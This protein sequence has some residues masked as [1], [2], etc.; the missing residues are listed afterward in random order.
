MKKYIMSMKLSIK[1]NSMFKMDYFLSF[2]SMPIEILII[3]LFWRNSLPKSNSIGYTLNTLVIYFVFFQTLQIAYVSAMFVAYEL[4]TKINDGTI[5]VWLIRP[6]SYPLYVFANKMAIFLPKFI[7]S[8]SVI[9]SVLFFLGYRIKT[10][11]LLLGILSAILGYIIL[12][13]IQYVI[14]SLTYYMKKVISFRDAV[15]SSLFLIGGFVL[16]VDFMPIAL[17]KVAYFTPMPYIYYVPSK[18]FCG[19][20]KMSDILFQILI[21]FVWVMALLAGITILWRVSTNNI[22]QGS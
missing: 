10:G 1:D 9:I 15:I 18:I 19:E 11:I 5:I 17:Q 8:L 14:G 21:Q 22:E 6:I 2:V 13:G 4:W 20:S 12:F 16:P 7:V 3:Y